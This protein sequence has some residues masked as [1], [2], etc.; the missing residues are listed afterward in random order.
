VKSRNRILALVLSLAMLVPIIAHLPAIVIAQDGTDSGKPF[1]LGMFGEP[2]YINPVLAGSIAGWEFINWIYDPL[3]RWDDDWGVKGGLAESW[4]WADN[5][6]QLTLHLVRNATWHDGT[7]FTSA[8]VNFTLFTWT[9]LGWWVAQTIRIDHYNIKCPDDYTVVLNFV[10][11]GYASIWAWAPAPTYAYWNERYDPTPVE[12]NQEC[13]LTGLTYVPI[14]PEHLWRPITWD[15]P[16]YGLNGSF[17]LDFD[18]PY[19]T[20]WGFGNWDAISWNI[21]VPTFDTPEVGTGMFELTEYATGEYA[22]FEAHD[23]Y[24]WGRPN[25]DNITVLFYDQV[26][27]MTNALVAG[28]I[29]F[30]ETDAPFVSIAEG[31]EGV[32]LNDRSFLGWEALLISQ[33]WLYCNATDKFSLREPA[34]KKAIN[35][36]VNKSKIAEIA[37]L[38]YADSAHSVVHSDLTKW[39]NDDLTLFDYGI[40]EAKTT[41]EADGWTL[42]GDGVYEKELNGSTK[43]LEYTL[44]YVSGAPVDLSMAQLIEADLEAAGFDITLQALDTTTF[45]TDTAAGSRNFDLAISFWSQIGDPNSICQ[46]MTSTSWIN[47]TGLSIPR[48]D[49]I[50][51]LQQVADTDTARAALV[52]EM[53]Q[54]VYDEASICILVEFDDLELYRSDRWE[55]THTDWTSGIFSMWNWESWLEADVLVITP[56]VFPIEMIAIVVGGVV[57]VIVI[58]IVIMKKRG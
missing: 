23:D 10:E 35:Q 1:K 30:C 38:G 45:L 22:F 40:A 20:F 11:N 31:T 28:E 18:P 32:T 51:R 3:I 39:F 19:N 52:D 41:L 7:P 42:N 4:E 6:T 33:D 27:P 17:Y 50:Y 44:K 12:V 9:W 2:D 5:G 36:A 14:L 29:D 26:E 57:L 25:I 54:L 55:F 56:V 47:P 21:I 53:Q 16:V 48:V 49:E 34:V 46:Y 24:H 37:Y 13:F 58:L 8:D 15:D 43:A